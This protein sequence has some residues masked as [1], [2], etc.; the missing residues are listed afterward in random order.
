MRPVGIITD[1]D[2]VVRVIAKNED[3]KDVRVGQVMTPDVLTVAETAVLEDALRLMENR[4]VRRMLVV[5]DAGR[6]RG[7]L[8]QGDVAL[9][10]SEWTAG[11]LVRE[12][13]E[14]AD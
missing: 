6:C 11:E 4:Q 14:P 7:I 13:S 10:A 12:V 3:P 9:A 1:R 5:D 2:I 8:S